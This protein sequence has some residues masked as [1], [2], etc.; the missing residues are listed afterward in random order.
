ML[1]TTSERLSMTIRQTANG[2]MK[3][4]RT[5]S[6]CLYDRVKIFLFAVDSRCH[7]STSV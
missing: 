6:S 2:K 5:V 7:L 3:L 1:G 4:L